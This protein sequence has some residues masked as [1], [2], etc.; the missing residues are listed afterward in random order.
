MGWARRPRAPSKPKTVQPSRGRRTLKVLG[1]DPTTGEV[2]LRPD[3]VDDLWHLSHVI[4]PGD[5]VVARTWRAPEEATKDKLRA[6]KVEK[7]AMTFAIRV[8]QVELQAENQRLR[9]LGVIIEG[10]QE[11]GAHHTLN[12]EPRGEVGLRKERWS[13]SDR[14][15]IEDAIASSKR[16]IL[17]ILAI[18]SDE[19]TIAAVRPMGLAKVA[20]IFGHVSGKRYGTDPK[21]AKEEFYAE[22]LEAVMRHVGEGPL[23]VVGPGFW[24]DEFVEF[25]R[26][27]ESSFPAAVRVE[28]TGQAGMT[29]VTEAIRRGAVDR[30]EGERRAADE[31]RLVEEFLEALGRDDPA[32]YGEA[33]VEAALDA[34]AVSLLL[35]ADDRVRGSGERLLEKARR[36]RA[37][38]FVVNAKSESGRKLVALGGFAALL[39]YRL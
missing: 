13:D 35:V 30:F 14:A 18:E 3:T 20:E 22:T 15:R 7:Q 1:E 16:P 33:Q 37:E 12:I 25:G 28:P 31:I 23:L 32:T 9:L 19:A 4:A 38:A 17:T 27:H 8:E 29:G 21:V 34:G 36:V 2:R 39:R 5:V 11:H 10:P 24:K 6:G 26:N